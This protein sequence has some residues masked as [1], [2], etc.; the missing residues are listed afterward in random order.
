MRDARLRA[1]CSGVNWMSRVQANAVA[2]EIISAA[3]IRL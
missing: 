3:A 2:G 1:S